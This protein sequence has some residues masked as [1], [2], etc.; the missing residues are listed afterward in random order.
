MVV[1]RIGQRL[2]ARNRVLLRREQI[3]AEH[4]ESRAG[5]A[6]R[7][8]L[9]DEVLYG[10]G[11]RRVAPHPH[12]IPLIA[13][14]DEQCLSLAYALGDERISSSLGRGHHQTLN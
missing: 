12:I 14:G 8:S 5:P 13:A 1:E 4:G 2:R 9:I 7:H 10:F 3:F 11:D 6:H